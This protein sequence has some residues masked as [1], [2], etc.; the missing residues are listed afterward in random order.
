MSN[1]ENKD[2]TAKVPLKKNENF[3]VKVPK[4]DMNKRP[5]PMTKP[6]KKD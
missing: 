2:N 1:Q 4:A 5:D 6:I 3:T